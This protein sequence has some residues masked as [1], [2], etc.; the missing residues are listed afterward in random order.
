[1]IFCNLGSGSK[2]NCTYLRHQQKAILIDQGFSLK[3]LAER[4][5]YCGLNPQDVAAVVVSHEHSD[6]VKGLGVFARRYQVPVYLTEATY[7]VLPPDLLKNVPVHFFQSGKTFVVEDYEIT[8]FHIP[9]DA[10]DPVGF[11]LAAGGKRAAIV[12]DLGSVSQAV[13]MHLQDLDLLF[14]EANHD[15]KMLLEGPYPLDLKHRIRSRVGHLSNEQSLELF[16]QLNTNGRL[17][18]LI[19]GH[20]SEI[21]NQPEIV[22]RIFH[23]HPACR[24]LQV[25]I[26]T[27]AMPT[28][29][30]EV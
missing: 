17:K 3:V 30:I 27:Q 14:L 8:P 12:T 6:H 9:H 10:A 13:L 26:A 25:T 20:L 16:N 2:G 5:V 19:L 4:F 23:Q 24:L 18:Q 22:S 21:N 28:P 1:M 15:L 7:A 29:I 11:I